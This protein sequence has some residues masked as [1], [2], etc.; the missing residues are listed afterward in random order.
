MN[1][2]EKL[3]AMLGNRIIR[4]QSGDPARVN[5]RAWELADD[6]HIVRFHREHSDESMLE[7]SQIINNFYQ[8]RTELFAASGA[9][10]ANSVSWSSTTQ[11]PRRSSWVVRSIEFAR[12]AINY[13]ESVRYR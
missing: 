8:S 1:S 12:H 13:A 10:R 9:D 3:E 4:L 6:Y 5:R 7:I 11:Q 2:N